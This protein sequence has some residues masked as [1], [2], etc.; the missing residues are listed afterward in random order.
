MKG[1]MDIHTKWIVTRIGKGQQETREL[2][3]KKDKQLIG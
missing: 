1:S 2:V 3:L